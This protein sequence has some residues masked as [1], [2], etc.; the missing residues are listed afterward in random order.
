MLYTPS[1]TD[2]SAA[3]VICVEVPTTGFGEKVAVTPAGAP[4]MFIG[5]AASNEVR[6]KEI[7]A[8]TS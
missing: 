2:A 6:V 7:G 3:I 4:T 5:T 1:E 8:L